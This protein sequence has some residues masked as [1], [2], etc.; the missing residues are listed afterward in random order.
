MHQQGSRIAAQAVES[1]ISQHRR[2]WGWFVESSSLEEKDAY[3]L[4]IHLFRNRQRDWCILKR[5][6]RHLERLGKPCSSVQVLRRMWASIRGQSE[7]R[8]HA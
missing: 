8:L 3:L 5:V 4:A 1:W 7:D 2:A 6:V